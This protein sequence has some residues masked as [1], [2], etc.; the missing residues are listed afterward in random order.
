MFK[1]TR[2]KL[3]AAWKKHKG[4]NAAKKATMQTASP[5]PVTPAKAGPAVTQTPESSTS[6]AVSATPS[7]KPTPR[8]LS[9]NSHHSAGSSA[10]EGVSAAA[11]EVDQGS[12]PPPPAMHV[13]RP[14]ET[15]LE[16][17]PEPQPAAGDSTVPADPATAVAHNQKVAEQ[18]EAEAKAQRDAEPENNAASESSDD[19]SSNAEPVVT[20]VQIPAATMQQIPGKHAPILKNSAPKA[21]PI[22]LNKSTNTALWV[23]FSGLATSLIA[24][25]GTFAVTHLAFDFAMM[26]A[27]NVSLWAGL[28]GLVLTAIALIVVNCMSKGAT[29]SIENPVDDHASVAGSADLDGGDG[30]ATPVA[31]PDQTT[32]NGIPS[33][34]ATP[35]AS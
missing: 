28:G 2:A 8:R 22:D 15:M 27:L 35:L 26:S 18:V 30:G 32:P 19:E 21:K 7:D 1:N 14:V 31:R 23:F 17:A 20:F 33:A 10:F 3:S 25:G 24:G 11:G 29:A 16:L 5:A 12:I 6:T 9:L 4:K 34:E 13:V